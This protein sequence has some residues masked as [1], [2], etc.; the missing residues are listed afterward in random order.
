MPFQ[1]LPLRRCSLL[2][3]P[4]L[5]GS[6]VAVAQAP[7]AVADAYSVNANGSLTVPA[8]SGVLANDTGFSP[9][10]HR[11]ESWDSRSRH[12]GVVA[13]AADGSFSY[14]PA[15]GFRGSDRF[16]YTVRN[17]FGA[18]RATVDIDVT[19]DVVWFVD[20]TAAAGGDGTFGS[21]FNSLAPVNGSLGLGD[22]DASSDS[23]FVYAGSYTVEF[24]LEPGQRLIGQALGLDLTGTQN[25]IAPG[26][27]PVLS[28]T[29][30]FPI[31]E[32]FGSGGQIRG[33]T[34][35]NTNSWAIRS[36]TGA[37]GGFTIA[38]VVVASS[39]TATGGIELLNTTGTL[40]LTN[41]SINGALP[42]SNPAL[43]ILG[44]AGTI[45]LANVDIGAGAGFTGGYV[46]NVNSNSGTI[47]FDAA[48]SL[49][50]TAT[51]GLTIQSQ[52]AGGSVTLPSI[53]V[54]GGAT[55]EPLIRL[56][57]NSATST[58]S[59]AQGVVANATAVDTTAFLSDGGR[60]TVGGTASALS[61]ADGPALYLESV[62][63]TA[64]ATFASLSSTSS[65]ARGISIDSPIGTHDV[66]VSGTTT[67]SSPTTEGIRLNSA[68]PSG[69]LLQMGRL[70]ASGGTTGIEV[71]NAAVS[72][73][74]GL[75]SLSTSAGP[76]I[77]CTTATTNLALTTLTAAGGSH[78]LDFNGCSGAVS[79]TTGSLASSAGAGNHVVNVVNTSGTNSVALTYGGTISKTDT[80]AAVNILGL[81][82]A[83][84][85]SLG[86][87]VTASNAT[88][89]ILITNTTRPVTFATLTLGSAGARFAS[90]PITIVGNTGAIDLGVLSSYT[91]GVPA[92]AINYANASPGLVTT[93]AGSLLDTS[94]ASATLT[95]DH[96]TSQALAL[97]FASISAPGAGTH[98]VDVN[99]GTGTLAV[100]GTSTFGAK[101]TAGVEVT[102]S[103]NL[104]VSF[105][106]LDITGAADG[107]RLAN[108]TAGSFTITGDGNFVNTHTNGA[109]G[110]FQNLTDNAF[111][112][113]TVANFRATDVVISGTGSHGLTGR[114]ISGTNV[115][116][117]VDFSNI[118]NA[119]NEHVFNLREGE[120]S[121]APASGSLEVNHSVIENFTDNG[122][123]LENFAGTLD[124]RWTDNVLR[125][126]ITTT[127]C[128]GGNCNG[129]GILLR[130]DGTARINA[131]I[132]N[133]VFE[134]ID[135]IGL[136]ANPEGS[137]GARM[138]IAVAQSAFT[139]ETYGGASNTNNGES[140]I[141]LR[142]AQGNSTLNFRLFSN[143]I[144]NYTGEFALGV[145]ALEG[146]DFTTTNG[147]VSDLYIY[148]AHEGGAVGVLSDGANTS[149]SGTTD[150]DLIL[151]F[152]NVRTPG[153]TAGSSFYFSA[154]GAISGSD[155][156]AQVTLV[157]SQFPSSPTKAFSRTV[158]LTF[159]SGVANFNRACFN[160]AG[161]QVAASSGGLPAIDLYYISSAQVR[162][163]GMVGSGDANAQS[164]LDSTNTLG[165]PSSVGTLNTITSATCTTPTLPAAF[166]FL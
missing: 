112:L 158:D 9:T 86:G 21:P 43:Q 151:S 79:A 55:G 26:A 63:L 156:N 13:V 100:S 111:D 11:L 45:S 128:G 74:D 92:L 103:N 31:I 119:D 24:D 145:V 135:G 46:L 3:V 87:T 162:L 166:P 89:G 30:S 14:D 76:A 81:T 163:Q 71:T 47:T 110:S 124:F 90:A 98:G 70:T 64:N 95:V 59:F 84:S 153:G 107:V 133:S 7:V 159:D 2:A 142:N 96:A 149:G 19:G 144:Y 143:D 123:Y 155:A 15:P 27:A 108:N 10:T 116:S 32:I 41:V 125:N 131:F 66:I 132:L 115:F 101:S 93:D 75:G 60:L 120:T 56:Q 105:Q 5:A 164:R 99:R 53:N 157:N 137:S 130:A 35:S 126:N 49:Q 44:N 51:R 140:A 4:L 69:F 28:N 17:A 23:I 160:I 68:A 139:A 37:N 58:A 88:S 150:Y 67:I 36:S 152:N 38:D 94:G 6:A 20:D 146:G 25:D 33:L 148:N 121:G 52:A 1:M 39:A 73:L 127:A 72:V 129:N 165:S 113:D 16:A 48:S 54:A 117:N 83:G 109:G 34:V 50:S 97:S 78:A 154:N 104:T 65:N 106:E 40:S 136:T 22:V 29:G 85:V 57:A 138:D 114:A 118:G 12:N 62:E 42:A 161:N 134:D 77:V 8:A 82:G 147:V 91:S 18:Q 80:G 141:S 61:A 102:N 122:V